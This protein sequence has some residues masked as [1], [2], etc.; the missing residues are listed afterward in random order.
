MPSQAERALENDSEHLIT[1]IL[2]MRE[3]ARAKEV[4]DLHRK[5]KRPKKDPL[6]RSLW[7][8]LVKEIDFEIAREGLPPEE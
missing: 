2:Y 4:Y 6:P 1:S 7:I 5:D 8:D 3:F